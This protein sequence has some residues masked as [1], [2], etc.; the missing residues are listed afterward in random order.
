MTLS[1]NP[2][3][4]RDRVLGVRFDVDDLSIRDLV[5]HIVSRHHTYARAAIEKIGMHVSRLIE[6]E[7]GGR[8][9][10]LRRLDVHLGRLESSLLLHMMKEELTLFPYIVGLVEVEEGIRP[11]V[12]APF[13][14]ID[15]PIHIAIAEHETSADELRAIR[16][17]T[18]DYLAPR[19]SSIAY[20]MAMGELGRFD[21]DF[22]AHMHL[23][24]DVL[25]P[26]AMALEQELRLAERASV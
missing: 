25:F 19:G 10:E 6:E 20:R 7:A 14:A 22:R 23:E 26:R 21:E 12:P 11:F 16:R 8:T 18:A 3:R 2:D 15:N 5:D 24:D 4:H 1:V 13:G 9:P 17:L